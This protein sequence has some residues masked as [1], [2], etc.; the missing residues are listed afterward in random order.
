[1]AIA[2]VVGLGNPGPEYAATRHNVG[3][4]VVDELARRGR[5]S[6]WRRAYHGML[7]RGG[8]G[9]SL[10]L[11][12]PATFMNLSGDAIDALCRGEHLLPQQ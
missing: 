9:A 7:A 10:V 8:R 6:A 1:M 11:L 2:A 3:F 12:K 4:M 5:A